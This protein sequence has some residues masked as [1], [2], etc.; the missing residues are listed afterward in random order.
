MRFYWIQDRTQQKHFLIYWKP[1]S[2]N[3][4]DYHTKHHPASHHRLMRS[5]Y[6]HPTPKLD[7]LV[8]SHILRGYV[9]SPRQL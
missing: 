2:T 7:N 6:L 8:I 4:G 1:G 9:K 5:T 3:L